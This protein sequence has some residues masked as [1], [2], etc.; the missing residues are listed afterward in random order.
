MTYE[1]RI[2][3]INQ[4][5]I[6]EKLYPD[7]EKDFSSRRKALEEGYV[8]HYEMID[9]GISKDELSAEECQEILNIL[10]MYRIIK[11]SYNKLDDKTGISI[12]P[13]SFPGFDGNNETKRM[14]YVEYFLHDLERFT[15]LHDDDEDFPDYNTHIESLEIYREMLTK[16]NS[17]GS[18]KHNL[19]GDRI[20]ELLKIGDV[21]DA[22]DE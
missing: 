21:F 18:E 13:K 16:F 1:Q 6:L 11:A 10:N 15:E 4:F 2:I 5:K 19:S 14:F 12:P 17:W 9:P 7:E 3:I 8:L 20:N 22:M